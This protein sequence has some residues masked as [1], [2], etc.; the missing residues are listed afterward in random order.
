MSHDECEEMNKIDEVSECLNFEVSGSTRCR[1]EL[2]LG[3]M[4]NTVQY[5]KT[6]TELD[7][8][9]LRHM[10]QVN[11]KSFFD[12]GVRTAHNTQIYII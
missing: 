2:C 9:H 5:D 12:A 4:S 8:Y 1:C 7:F 3:S 6:Y 10:S 11:S